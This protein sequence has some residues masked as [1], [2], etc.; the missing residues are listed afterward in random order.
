MIKLRN[1]CGH[2]FQ[3]G[4]I[5][6]KSSCIGLI[7]S[8]CTALPAG[9]VKGV[10]MTQAVGPGHFVSIQANKVIAC[11]CSSCFVGLLPL[12]ADCRAIL[13]QNTASIII[14]GVRVVSHSQEVQILN[15][16][17]MVKCFL[18]RTRAIGN[19]GVCMQLTE[20]NVVSVGKPFRKVSD[21]LNAVLITILVGISL[22]RKLTKALFNNNRC[23]IFNVVGEYNAIL[24]GC[25]VN[26]CTGSVG[27]KND[28][29]G[30]AFNINAT[31]IGGKLYC[32]HRASCIGIHQNNRVCPSIGS[33]ISLYITGKS[34]QSRLGL[35][36][37]RCPVATIHT[38]V[39]RCT[40]SC[41]FHCQFSTNSLIFRTIRSHCNVTG[42]AAVNDRAT[43]QHH[44]VNTNDTGI[45][46]RT[47]SLR[48]ICTGNHTNQQIL[49]VICAGRHSKGKG[50]IVGRC[51]GS[52]GD[53]VGNCTVTLD[54]IRLT[55]TVVRSV[56][57][58]ICAFRKVH[59]SITA[60]LGIAQLEGT[61]SGITCSHTERQFHITP[62]CS[63]NSKLCVIVGAKAD[64]LTSHVIAGSTST[65]VRSGERL[66]IC[67]TY[68]NSVLRIG[69]QLIAGSISVALNYSSIGSIAIFSAATPGSNGFHNA[70]INFQTLFCRS[71]LQSKHTLTACGNS[72]IAAPVTLVLIP[73]NVALTANI[74]YVILTIACI[75]QSPFV[76]DFIQRHGRESGAHGQLTFTARNGNCAIFVVGNS[77]DLRITIARNGTAGNS[78]LHARIIVRAIVI[79]GQGHIV[80][81]RPNHV[82]A[83]CNTGRTHVGFLFL[84]L[85]KGNQS[86]ICNLCFRGFCISAK[87]RVSLI[88]GNILTHLNVHQLHSAIF[89]YNC[90]PQVSALRLRIGNIE[91]IVS[92]AHVH[93]AAVGILDSK[94]AIRDIFNTPSCLLAI[95]GNR[96]IS[97]CYYYRLKVAIGLIRSQCSGG[98]TVGSLINNI[99]T[100][101][102]S[103]II[104]RFCYLS[105]LYQFN[106]CSISDTKLITVIIT[107]NCNYVYSIAFTNSIQCRNLI[108]VDGAIPYRQGRI[109]SSVDCTNHSILDYNTG[110]FQQT[111]FL[112]SQNCSNGSLRCRQP[113]SAILAVFCDILQLLQ[114]IESGT[115]TG[116]LNNITNG[117]VCRGC[118]EIQ[119]NTTGAVLNNNIFA[120]YENNSTLNGGS[121]ISR[122]GFYI[123]NRRYGHF[124]GLLRN[125]WLLTRTFITGTPITTTF[126][127]VLLGSGIDQN[128]TLFACLIT[129]KQIRRL[130]VAQH[131]ASILTLCN[132]AGNAICDFNFPGS[133]CCFIL[134]RFQV[135]TAGT[136]SI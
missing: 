133:I 117:N 127:V 81:R 74:F 86:Q 45:L 48:C 69:I 120:I 58:L 53:T 131:I 108:D 101:F 49:T 28:L 32:C 132:N 82:V 77:P 103:H 10:H 107:D 42:N 112:V 14:K 84:R 125:Y 13:S 12:T 123:C 3:C 63:I 93:K 52:F 56:S 68:H 16:G 104:F 38:I 27:G 80:S 115:G 78:E 51:H 9:R 31:A 57:V 129:S 43:R 62:A 21:D 92:T 111:C 83:V 46:N 100:I 110:A 116:S 118:A 25:I 44:R 20:V 24:R 41:R 91:V 34:R 124:T 17:S 71:K 37:V 126:I 30:L 89:V 4:V 130:V 5:V 121:C 33:C 106:P 18:D 66:N 23:S 35:C 8:L 26:R 40:L 96:T 39:N 113:C 114:I 72:R 87:G 15:F 55:C 2:S 94:V 64:A 105:L 122:H 60:I 47:A 65:G 79:R 76:I 61:G 6:I 102:D 75:F 85:H 50:D 19:I 7:I 119:V 95:A 136:C 135:V 29:R 22:H 67:A 70:G 36:I 99:G 1:G 73:F 128:I 59:P 97:H 134:P 88:I 54:N 11:N 109:A 98:L 90:S